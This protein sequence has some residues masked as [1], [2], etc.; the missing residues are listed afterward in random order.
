LQARTIK[1]SFG[2]RIFLGIIYALLF[3]VLISILY[4]L[5][6]IVSASFSSGDAI[7]S[8]RVWLLPVEPTLRGYEAIFNNPDVIS[9][10]MNTFIYTVLGTSIAVVLTIALAYPLSKNSFVGRKLIM[11]LLVVT[12]L[13]DGGL[14]PYYLTVKSYNMLDTI[15]AMVIPGAIGIWQVI[16]ART[17]FQMTIPD[18]LS[19]ASE[20]DG[21]S[22]IRYL[23]SIVIPLSKPI[24]AVLVLMYAVSHWN[25]YF[26]A[27][28]FLK[29]KDKFPLQLILRE[30]LILNSVDSMTTNME[31]LQA[32]Q[33]LSQLLK[34]S[35]I[36]IS[37][38]PILLFYP[39]IQK[40]FVKGML[41][42]SV[43]G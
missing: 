7:R 21:C 38:G 28:I 5:V 6:Y 19:E 42:G 34:Y 12:M 24:I 23:W 8:G 22:D 10:F 36:V 40:Y 14:I 1:D 33:D 29:S 37:T 35:L 32:K 18:E 13:F 17:F 9:G 26:D 31:E 20:L 16:I 27:L 11:V 39:F 30:I 4:P 2:D 3:I 15:W 25:A 41:I 43:K